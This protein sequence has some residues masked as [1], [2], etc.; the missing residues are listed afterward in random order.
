MKRN[1]IIGAVA[2]AI[3]LLVV[4]PPVRPFFTVG[5]WE[6]AIVTQFG[7]FKRAI[8]EPG[9]HW[10]TP[11][12][13]DVTMYEKRILSSDAQPRDY[14]T[15]DKKR[16]VVDHVT[17]WKIADPLKFFKTAYDESR[18]RFLLDDIVFSELRQELASR[19]FGEIISAEREAA[20]EEVAKRAAKKATDEYG[21][22]VVDVRV[23]RADLPPEV[24]QSVF[25]RMRAERE[26]I[27]KRYRSEGAEESAKIRAITDREKT[28][29]LAEAYRTSQKLRGE[30]DGEA[31]AIY[32]ESYGQDPDFYGF[33]RSLEAYE[34][35]LP[36]N[37]TAI[38]SEDSRLFRHLSSAQ[39]TMGSL[40]GQT[41][42]PKLGAPA[43]P[44]KVTE[45]T[46]ATPD[47]RP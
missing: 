40:G 35:F 12:I 43:A 46:P 8:R 24:Q 39:N 22:T 19:N 21:I 28:I 9:L 5:E 29:I 7:K 36:E 25:E 13:E 1:Y 41:T 2:A 32:A 14:L 15:L 30:G 33:A 31:T 27:A 44:P 34:K 10:K 37:S 18:G 3:V 45:A 17:R 11:F 47:T 6:Q 16:V 20:M 26:R 38:L 23:K 42:S 4:F